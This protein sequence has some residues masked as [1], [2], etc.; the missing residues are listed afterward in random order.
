M[1]DLVLTAL[2]NLFALFCTS[3][4]LKRERAKSVIYNYL[5]R[6]FGI[7]NHQEY[8]D[9][10]DTLC[11]F[12]ELS[13][14]DE[15]KIV[16]QVCEKLK[17]EITEETQVLMVLRLMEFSSLNIE[18]YHEQRHLFE[19]VAG[20][21]GVGDRLFADFERFIGGQA[22]ENVGIKH[23]D[24]IG[25][26]L[27][28]LRL[29]EYNK[30]LVSAEGNVQLFMN[31]I[32][33]QPGIFMPWEKNGIIKSKHGK[34]LYYD[35]IQRELLGTAEQAQA[36]QFC[37]H[38]VD[39]RFPNSDNGLHDF[40]FRL[41]SGELVAIMGGSGTGKSTLM[42]ILNGSQRPGSGS[43]TINGEE[44]YGNVERLKQLIGFVPQ[45]DLLIA[46]L[47][48]WQ[49]LYYTARF[50]DGRMT[51]EE[52]DRRITKTLQDLDLMAIKDLRVG[53]PLDKTI[54]GGQR[55]RLNIALELIREPQILFLDEP[56]SGL[57]STDS[58]KVIHLLKSQTYQGRLVITCI[59]QPSSDIYKLF[60]RL[61]L[62]DRGGYPIYDGNPI[63]AVGFFKAAANYADADKAICE[64]CG[65]INPEVVL[66]IV[67]AKALD[68]NGQFTGKRKVEPQEWNQI[69]MQRKAEQAEGEDS[70]QS[71][72]PIPD[73]TQAKPSALKQLVIYLRRNLHT[74]LQDKQ[75][76]LI[77]A[78]E[79]PVLALIVA[80]LTRYSGEG[81]YT[82][83][84]NKNLLPYMFMAIIVAV[85]MGMSTNAEEIF[86]DRALLKRESFLQLSHASYIFSKV[87]TAAI[88]SMV[89]TLLFVLVG[90]TLM[91]I[92]CLLWQWWG[93]MFASSFLAALTGLV[94]SQRLKSLV[95][96]YITIPLLLIPQ[97]L[98]CGVV[99]SFD[100]LNQHSATRNVPL[101]GEVIPSR[102]AFESIA[103]AMF[104]DNDYARPY[105]A[106]EKKQYELQMARLGTINKLNELT[107]QEWR[108]RRSGERD[109]SSMDVIRN[110]VRKLADR[111]GLP[112]FELS[113]RLKRDSL[114]EATY[115][116]LKAWLKKADQQLYTTSTRYTRAIDKDK[117]AYIKAHGN[118]ALVKLKQDNMNKQL[119]L[120]LINHNAGK[121][122]AVEQGVIV[123]QMGTVYLDPPQHNGRAPFYSSV[124]LI[125]GCRIP[126][127][128]FNLSVLALMALATIAL[129]LTGGKG[130]NK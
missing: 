119:E 86:K 122:V 124:K 32:P 3:S 76:L 2:I 9:L 42:S 44:L 66:N 81:G 24:E 49:N 6:F 96:I 27:K 70:H 64:T 99:V 130:G 55:K 72:A 1:N 34:P 127:L 43:I 115:D 101:I 87:I 100:D 67:D 50:C 53:S 114:D 93:V 116:A 107:E 37:G 68:S 80:M 22:G 60:D 8:L 129:L 98:L 63:E 125:G 108:A 54:S 36:I 123:P 79:A 62:L 65:N 92:G 20:K 7:R 21:F 29:P 4:N 61:W 59:H 10:Y 73:R 118:K 109:G 88:I 112:P 111:W 16:S 12:Y 26:T 45:D 69:Y 48:V 13:A 91:G 71:L 56:T 83:Y 38:H 102:W 19:L 30:T 90:N 75:F 105:F 58:E 82:L 17:K 47:T 25:S 94:L 35:F 97:I 46:E 85:F 106:N 89:Q 52:L 18:A 5:V 84:E 15:Q 41:Q 128:P 121:M 31:D 113:A 23:I 57:S 126:T 120:T 14:P 78:L 51:A 33:I 39:F 103:V 110:E 74:K 104:T 11:D 117:K 95:A 28:V 77:A 40:T